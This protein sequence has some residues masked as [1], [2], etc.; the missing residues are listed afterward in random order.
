LKGL[1]KPINIEEKNE[2]GDKHREDKNSP[3]RKKDKVP[4]DKPG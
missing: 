4:G 2:I 3:V 1:V